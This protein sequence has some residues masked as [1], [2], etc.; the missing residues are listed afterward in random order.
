[1]EN[2]AYR[3]VNSTGN[4]RIAVTLNSMA[5]PTVMASYHSDFTPVSESNPAR[6]GEVLI[7]AVKGLGPT[8]PVLVP[9]KT[10]DGQALAVVSAP[11]TVT[12]NDLPVATENQVGWP[13][14]SD[15]YR[16]D[17]TLPG[18]IPGGIAS[19]SV[20]AAWIPGPEF[21]IPVR[22]GQ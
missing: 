12:I 16:V 4:W 20:A 6:A 22:P 19:V 5:V 3:R 15:T 11:V 10:F 2:P 17:V 21:R 14:T 7:L 1:M 18:G 9:G 13:G 8:N